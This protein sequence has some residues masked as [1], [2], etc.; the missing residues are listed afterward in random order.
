VISEK[1]SEILIFAI[2]TLLTL[3]ISSRRGHRLFININCVCVCMCVCVCVFMCVCVCVCVCV[4][5]TS[6]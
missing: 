3:R 6:K 2:E 5:I 1:A 4:C